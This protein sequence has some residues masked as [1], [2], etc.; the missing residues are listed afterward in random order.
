[1]V[2]SQWTHVIKQLRE[3]AVIVTGGMVCFS[4][5]SIYQGNEKFYSQFV[6]PAVKILSP[7]NAH[8]FGVALAKYRLF[9]RSSVADPAILNTKVWDLEFRNPVGV[10]AGFDKHGEAVDGLLKIGFGF[11]EVGSITPK[12]QPGN[13]KPRVFRLDEDCA[14]INRYGFNSDGHEVVYNRLMERNEKTVKKPGILGINLGKNKTSENSEQDYASGVS[15]FGQLA[16]FLVVNIS[17]PNT[18]GL[19][20]LQGREN[21]EKLIDRVLLE[22]DQ[23]K[24]ERKPPIL[25]KIAPDL[26]ESDRQDIAHVVM[27]EHSLIDGLII[28]NT[29]V[30]RDKS[31]IS[32]NRKETGGLSGV[33][34]R[35]MSTQILSD[36]YSLT[37]GKIPIIGVGGI[38]SGKD[39][40]DKIRA[41]ASLVELYTVMTYQGPVVVNRIKRELAELLQ[42][43]GYSSVSDAVGADHRSS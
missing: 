34:L 30:S 25:V 10:A 37:Q 39:A 15:L 12:P 2:S 28:S 4:G 31:L 14:V 32:K 1:M 16:D 11:V 3:V 6:M 42:K 22:R 19:R 33:P 43:D 26:T 27:R 18:P 9:G 40:Y 35:E 36:M 23:L 24:C 7:E 17:S 41:G 20:N 8:R 38:S 29:T 13:P 5:I 21:L